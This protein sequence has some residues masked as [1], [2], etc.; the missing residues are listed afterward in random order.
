MERTLLDLDITSADELKKAAALDTAA[1]QLIL[2]SRC[3][4]DAVAW[5]GSRP[6]SGHC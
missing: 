1:D 5:P 3:R 4:A 2:R 6:V